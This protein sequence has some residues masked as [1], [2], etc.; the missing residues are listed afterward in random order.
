MMTE[1]TFHT[2]KSLSFNV[3][4]INLWII[5]HNFYP[6]KDYS[7]LHLLGNT[8]HRR[9]QFTPG[10]YSEEERNAYKKGAIFTT[11][12]CRNIMKIY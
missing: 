8:I 11:Q 5:Y 1:N 4:D 9:L 2:V 7:T 10:F 6:V 12:Q 3:Q